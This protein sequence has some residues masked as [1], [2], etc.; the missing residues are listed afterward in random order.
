M[1]ILKPYKIE[2][3]P[4]LNQHWYGVTLGKK[5]LGYFPSATTILNAYPTSEH[6]T[7]WIA[8]NGWHESRAL[9][10][11]AG[12]RGT[13]IHLGVEN[14]IGGY[15]L[16]QNDYTTEEWVKL[17]SF[18]KWYRDYQPEI[19]A[20]EMAIFS[21]KGG[22]AGRLDCI[23]KVNGQVVVIDWKSSKAIH[24]SFALQVASY[25]HAIEE[26]TDLKITGTSILQ[27]GASNKN[28]YRYAE[29]VN[30]QD[31]YKV[32]QNV[33]ATWLYDNYGSRKKVKDP[34]ILILPEKLSL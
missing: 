7:K 15:T 19:I 31:N 13:R 28:G 11:A 30:W 4:T 21:K 18:V 24:E 25:A 20:T 8:E 27:L 33:R 2:L 17:E 10:D 26:M 29:Y 3:A 22:Y 16:Q 12:Q 34:P 23:A 1:K 14:L 5:H 32:F 6:L 9:R